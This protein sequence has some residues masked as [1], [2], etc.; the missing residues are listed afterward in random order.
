M[1]TEKS[2]QDIPVG[3]RIYLRYQTLKVGV[4]VDT[5][6]VEFDDGGALRLIKAD[7]VRAFEV[8]K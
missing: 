5:D 1:I 8:L 4:K 6:S 2:F 7:T 3:T